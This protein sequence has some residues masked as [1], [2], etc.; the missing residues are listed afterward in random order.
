MDLSLKAH[1]ENIN[2]LSVHAQVIPAVACSKPHKVKTV[3]FICVI[4]GVITLQVA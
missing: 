4:I 3:R 2:E 1:Q